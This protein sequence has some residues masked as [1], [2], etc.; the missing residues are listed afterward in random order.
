MR[1]KKQV[2][3][4]CFFD[5]ANSSFTTVV[6]TAIFN[7]YFLKTISA[8]RSDGALLWSLA[9]LVSNF[10]IILTAP[11]IGAVADRSGRKKPFLLLS[12]LVCVGA[13]AMLYFAQEGDV[14]WALGFFVVA[15]FAFACGENL[16]AGFLPELAGPEDMAR[17]SA[18]GWGIGY[19][20]G[21]L[22]L[23]VSLFVM[24]NA[25][26]GVR[27]TMLVVALFFLLGGLPTFFFV[28]EQKREFPG[29]YQALSEGLK[30]SRQ[31]LRNRA[32]LPDLFRFFA[33]TML[34]QI[35]IYGVIQYA[36]IYGSKLV[37][38]SEKEIAK[39]LMA[40][41]I[42]AIFGALGSGHLAEKIGTL[43]TLRLSTIIWVVAAASILVLPTASGFWFAALMAG[44]AM[45]ACLT[46]IRA[47][48]GLFAPPNK[49]AEFFGFWGFFGRVAA[50]LAPAGN[51]LCLYLSSDDLRSG[52]FYFL[53]CF[54][55]GFVLLARV[56]ED[57]GK[58]QGAEQRPV[59]L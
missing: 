5:F 55:A 15:N 42:T 21:L 23:L 6:V 22:A 47:T 12:Y 19:V 34:I 1:P 37:E 9:L 36:G 2:W 13:T 32:G 33:A 24:A 29:I 48:V 20:G 35:G 30:A 57:R 17:V 8:H 52:I 7:V 59:T 39:I 38:L 25:D 53:L 18:W 14:L 27:A 28:Q 41:Q 44:F 11:V 51:A 45:G 43:G 10:L 56:N 58:Q 4:W 31:T 3:S 16:V 50:L 49:S 46:T 54:G 26:A 40:S